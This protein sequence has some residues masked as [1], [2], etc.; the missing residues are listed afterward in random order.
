[1]GAS[2]LDTD[3]FLQ[4]LEQDLD[5]TILDSRMKSMPSNSPLAY[6]GSG[7]LIDMNQDS[8]TSWRIRQLNA[9]LLTMVNGSFAQYKNSHREVLTSREFWT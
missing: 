6:P 8:C 1:M 2:S 5:T 3:E 7:S 4:R 9:I